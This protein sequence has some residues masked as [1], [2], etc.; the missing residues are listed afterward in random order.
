MRKTKQ[1][2]QWNQRP[3]AIKA[4]DQTNALVITAD[5]DMMLALGEV[6]EN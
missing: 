6:I 3:V 1:S 4:Y 2:N 5:P